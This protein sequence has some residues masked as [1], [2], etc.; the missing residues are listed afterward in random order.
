[1]TGPI[2]RLDPGGGQDD[3]L[4]FA[5]VREDPLLE[6]DVLA[7]ALDGRVVVV[8]SGGCTALSLL[9]RG[10]GQVVAVDLNRTQL[11][12]V[13]LKALAVGEL[14]HEEATAFLGGHGA[15][16]EQRRRA[17]SRLAPGLSPAAR[18]Y[19]SLH[20][21]AID[22]GVLG[23]GVT[24]RF[25][26]TV[27]AAL[28]TGVHPTGR[29]ERML[30]APTLEAQQRLF[31]SE[32]DTPR[33]RAF[34]AVLLNRAV[35]RRAYDPAFFAH[36]DNPSF[37]RHFRAAADHTLTAIP[38]ATNYFVHHMLT[39]RYPGTES[40]GV[41]PYL[42]PDPDRRGSDA[43]ASSGGDDALGRLTLVATDVASYLA[44]QPAQSVDGFALSNICEWL[45]A[46]QLHELLAQ[47]VRTAVAGAPLVI[48]NFLGWTEIP[49]A[50]AGRI[51]E[52]RPRGE[53]LILA[54][55]SAVQRRLA[56]CR[57]T[58]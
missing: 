55:R 19:W 10:Q 12:L 11:H 18:S 33:W 35:L 58:G 36:V 22:K 5:Q 13:E 45:T 49:P 31:A 8:A 53:T 3:R 7:P 42:S 21:R 14:G 20:S 6:L 24:E 57:V 32:W 51:E 27:V 40:G 2:R 43:S 30:A 39:G 47:V 1:M 34:F 25:I 38:I 44:T 37:A 50:W 4:F 17:F 15:R 56:A 16:P 46:V 48:R 41:P 29:I 23:S 28:R 26:A 9:H 52:D 54:D